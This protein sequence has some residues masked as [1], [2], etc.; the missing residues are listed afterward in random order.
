MIYL[1]FLQQGHDF[2]QY[3]TF[4]TYAKTFGTMYMSLASGYPSSFSIMARPMPDPSVDDAGCQPTVTPTTGVVGRTVV[5]FNITYNCQA[6]G[7][8][9]I[10]LGINLNSSCL[11]NAVWYVN[12]GWVARSTLRFLWFVRTCLVVLCVFGRNKFSGTAL[13]VAT[14]QDL[15]DNPD[16]VNLGQTLPQWTQPST[17]YS[18]VGNLPGVFY[19]RISHRFNRTAQP[20]AGLIAVSDPNYLSLSPLIT[21]NASLPYT[22][23]VVMQLTVDFGCANSEDGGAVT[24]TLLNSPFAPSVFQFFKQ[25]RTCGGIRFSCCFCVDDQSCCAC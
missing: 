14:S 10:Y 3:Y 22:P 18:S 24:V 2:D 9:R 23:N 4:A 1:H 5:P 6:I 16:V 13:V 8:T 19:M 11:S 20:S 12:A 17:V 21:P 15:L 25:C 7:R